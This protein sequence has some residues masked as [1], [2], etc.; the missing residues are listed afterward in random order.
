MVIVRA[1]L[2][3]IVPAAASWW[4]WNGVDWFLWNDWESH[5]ETEKFAF[6]LDIEVGFKT[7]GGSIPIAFQNIYRPLG[8]YLLSFIIHDAL[9]AGELCTRAEAD[10]ILLELLEYQGACWARRNTVYSAVRAGGVFVWAKHTKKSVDHA[11]SFLKFTPVK[12]FEPS[13]ISKSLRAC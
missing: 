9:Y 7:D 13:N 2:P 1:E 4:K 8:K 5:I 12:G 11:R 6:H 10:W 3:V